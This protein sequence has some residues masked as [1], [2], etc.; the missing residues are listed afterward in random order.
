M[1]RPLL[2]VGRWD[3]PIVET[4][5][6]GKIQAVHVSKRPSPNTDGRSRG[7]QVSAAAADAASIAQALPSSMFWQQL[8]HSHPN[9]VVHRAFPTSSS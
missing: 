1:S 9:S 5:G 7:S 2:D 6:V 3:E 4:R 8:R